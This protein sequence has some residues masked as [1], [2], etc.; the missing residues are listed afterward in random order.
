M[1]YTAAFFEAFDEEERILKSLLPN[2]LECFFTWRTIQEAGGERP[3]A[4]IVSVRTQS[5]L[6]TDWAEGIDAIITRSTGYDHVTEFLSR[7][8]A[9]ID[10]AYLPDYAGR[11]V[12]EQAMLLWTALLRK[13]ELQRASFDAFHRDDLTGRELVG[14]ALTVVGVG[15]IG[16]QIVDVAQGLKMDVAGVDIAP[17]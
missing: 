16:S 4:P 17:R 13:L 11:A 14:R 1:K 3:P 2:E 9:E 8:N 12:A 5:A 10:A 6:P 15:R 7:T